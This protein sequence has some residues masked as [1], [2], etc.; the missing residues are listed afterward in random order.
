MLLRKL[1]FQIV[2]NQCANRSAKTIPLSHGGCVNAVQSLSY[3]AEFLHLLLG[4]WWPI[5]SKYLLGLLQEIDQK[6][7]RGITLVV[8]Q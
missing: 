4:P 8:A 6:C 3:A 1:L 7:F 2:N 5:V